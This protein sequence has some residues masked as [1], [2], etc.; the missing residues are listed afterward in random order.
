MMIYELKQMS[1][2]TNILTLS[3]TLCV[4]ALAASSCGVVYDDYPTPDAPGDNNSSNTATEVKLSFRLAM[5]DKAAPP[6]LASRTDGSYENWG[7]GISGEFPDWDPGDDY[8]NTIDPRSLRVTIVNNE[9]DLA[10]TITSLIAI[11]DKDN[12]NNYTFEGT[13]TGKDVSL[14]SGKQYKI[15]ITA[16]SPDVETPAA[17]FFNAAFDEWTYSWANTEA[18]P[19][20]TIPMYGLVTK[21][22]DFT[23]GYRNEIGT[24][25]LL[26]AAAKVDVALAAESQALSEYEIVSVAIDRRNAGGFTVPGGVDLTTGATESISID[27]SFREYTV[28][29]TDGLDFYPVV[30]NGTEKFRI[31]IPEWDNTTDPDTRATIAV[32]VRPRGEEDAETTTFEGDRGIRFKKYTDDA[33]PA[34]APTGTFY[35]VIR[36]HYYKFDIQNIIITPEEDHLRFRVTIADMEKGGDWTY[37]Y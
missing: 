20:Q 13:V 32:T 11:R 23:P 6:V 10:A 36:N 15:V 17:G 29:A 3:L 25:H 19:A 9:G 30:E 8:D 33:Y 5:N 18:G 24:I 4:V 31:Y 26:R 1:L 28:A 27:D 21:T 22:L 7:E 34:D 16:N 35:N 2:Q 14:E 37:E 12:K